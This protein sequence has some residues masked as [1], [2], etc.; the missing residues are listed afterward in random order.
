MSFARGKQVEPLER[1]QVRA[2]E[3]VS[4]TFYY[5]LLVLIKKTDRLYAESTLHITDKRKTILSYWN[6]LSWLRSSDLNTRNLT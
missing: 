1:L 5:L 3:T 4:N 6:F 2:N